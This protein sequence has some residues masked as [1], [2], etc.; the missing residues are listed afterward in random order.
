[1]TPPKQFTLCTDHR[2]L[3]T[4]STVH[5]KRL[6]NLQLLMLKFN[7]VIE[8]KEGW[9]N[10]IADTLSRTHAGV[11]I[12]VVTRSGRRTA[13]DNSVPA[14]RRAEIEEEEEEEEEQDSANEDDTRDAAPQPREHD[15][16][17]PP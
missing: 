10:T 7:F 13:E 1:L 12:Y 15:W 11:P 3:K 2:P 9:R 6:N 16:R 8:Y 4:M 5:K 17:Q 14:Y